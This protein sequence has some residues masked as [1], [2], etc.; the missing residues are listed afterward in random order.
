MGGFFLENYSKAPISAAGIHQAN[1]NALKSLRPVSGPMKMTEIDA[2][3]IEIPPAQSTPPQACPPEGR[4]R[5]T[6]TP[7]TRDRPSGV[8]NP[9]AHPQRCRQKETMSG[10]FMRGRGV[11]RNSQGAVSA[12]LHDVVGATGD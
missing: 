4:D 7:E 8:S 5:V 1:E 10:Q 3:Q 12:A 6:W 9:S 11:S 2:T